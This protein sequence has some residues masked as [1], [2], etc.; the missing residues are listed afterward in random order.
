M[1]LRLKYALLAG[2]GLSLAAPINSFATNGYFLIGFGAKSRAMGGTGVAYNMGAMVAAVNPATLID[3]TDSID[4]GAELFRPPRAI[5]HDSGVLGQTNERSNHDLFMIPS[6][7][8][9]YKWDDKLVFGAAMI[10]AGLKTEYDQTANNNACSAVGGVGCPPTVFNVL[11][12]N[13]TG[14]AGVEL[15]QIQMLPSVAYKLDKKH[16]VG[17]TIVLAGQYFRAEGLADFGV[18]GFTSGGGADPNLG[19]TDVG[20]SHSFGYGYRIGWLTKFM[21]GDLN[22]GINY[23]ARVHMNPFSRYTRLFAEQGDFDIPENYTFGFAYKVTPSVVVAL[24]FQRINYSNIASVGNPGPDVNNP[25]DFFPLCP[26]PASTTPCQLGGDQGLGFG[27][28]DQQIYKLGVDWQYSEKLALRAGLNYGK[29]PIPADQVLFNM[30]APATPEKHIT[31]G[32]EYNFNPDYTLS[33][34]YMH[35]FLNTIKG[36]TAF[37][38]GGA[39]VTGHNA[40]IA[41][42]QDSLGAALT[43]KF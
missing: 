34:N 1:S 38:V 22:F 3:S 31:I 33:V 9:V 28:T 25:S 8:G 39:I 40:S 26:P 43:I 2:L 37:G 4:L 36:P 15:Y 16:T 35:A 32:A 41:M 10:G 42:E 12:N 21:D 30:L 18:L 14:E 23:S 24:D 7:G 5:Q 17:A 19:L 20:F 6:L 29:A 11:N 27:W 13:A